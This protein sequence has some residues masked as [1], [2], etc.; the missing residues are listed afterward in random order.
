VRWG[1][2]VKVDETAATRVAGTVPLRLT[3]SCQAI[4]QMTE[5]KP[6]QEW[7]T[8]GV[9]Q[10]DG[11]PLPGTTLDA[12]LVRVDS[13]TFLVYGNY[14]ALLGYNCAHAYAL[15]VGLLADRIDGAY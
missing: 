15:G 14:E 5:S 2:E 9:R 13:R 3:G 10:V 8:L 11:K 4:R 12:S 6:I 1:R 7:R